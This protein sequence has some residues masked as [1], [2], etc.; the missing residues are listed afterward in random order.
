MIPDLRA[1]ILKNKIDQQQ[2]AEK[3]VLQI[4]DALS[5]VFAQLQESEKQ[6]Y[7][8]SGFTSV[9][10]FYGQPVNV[11][12]QQDTLEFYNV[13]CDNIENCSPE[14]AKQL[15]D[16]VGGK[17]VNETKSIEK[18]YPYVSANEEPF[19]ALSLDIKNKKNL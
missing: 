18:E 15:R 2:Y 1:G 9:F 8:P 5:N 10:Q 7:S 12:E 3:P 11:R 6:Y 4:L 14:A 13:L 16:T 17:L 19:F